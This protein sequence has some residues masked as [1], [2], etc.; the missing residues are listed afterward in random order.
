M[1]RNARR[2]LAAALALA[3]AAGTLTAPASAD[4]AKKPKLSKTSLALKAGKSAKVKIKN[5][6]AK[7][8]KKLTVKTSAKKTATVK[9]NGKTA[10]TV[11]GKKKGSATIT[12]GVKVGKKTTNLKLR[13]K[14]A[15]STV[16]SKTPV[17]PAPSAVPPAT[18]T[19]APPA[20]SAPAT[21]APSDPPSVPTATPLTNYFEDFE[22]GLNGWY[23]RGNEGENGEPG[24]I[25]LEL[26]DEAH[27]GSHSALITGREG[28]DGEGHEWNGPAIDLT[29]TI[30]PGGKYRAT[31]YA[32]VPSD[33][34]TY[35][36]GIDI[37][38]SGAMS[39]SEDDE[40]FENYPRDTWHK[41]PID[42]WKEISVEF[43]VPEYFQSYILYV[44]TH[45]FGKA[46]FLIDDFRLELV[47]APAAYDPSLPSIREAYAP[48]I[49]VMGV[50]VNYGQ[51]LNSN[52]LAFIKHHFNSITMGNEM[53]IDNMLA[54]KETLTLEEAEKRGY[55]VSEAYKACPDNKDAD[56]NVIVPEISFTQTDRVLA[57]AK[58]NGL[59]V[60][61]HSPFWHSQMPQH[62]FTKGYKDYSDLP[63]G[64]G[65]FPERYT[66]KETMYARE[67]MYVQTILH[68]IIEGGY[69][70]TVSS[71]DVVNEYLH[72]VFASLDKYRNFWQC[73]FGNKDMK[74]PYVKKAF[75][76]AHEYLEKQ[77]KRDKIS[78]IYND[79]STYDEVDEV[80]ELINNINAK[81]DMNPTG[82]KVCDGI[83]MQSHVGLDTGAE[84]YENAIKAF[85]AA[86]F[87]IQIT[88]LDVNSGTV[89]SET[90]EEEKAKVWE[91]N[92]K[93]Y[94]EIM[95]VI[96]RQKAKGA[97]ITQVTV[98]GITDAS[99]WM[100]DVAPLLFGA[101]VA[102]KK[103]SFDA[104]VNAALNFKK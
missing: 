30:M 21:Q 78:L 75:V 34:T 69:E 12:A 20:A 13:V 101:T 6:K 36:R 23:G 103:P 66:D 80:I 18:G 8:V 27:S 90:T 2:T 71:F 63:P 17:P 72:M 62:F 41:I 16:P 65:D 24:T 70:D 48:Y 4:A 15:A 19:Q 22:N 55:V 7:K 39:Y 54:T 49:P 3:L 53:K 92:A 82:A 88:E 77:G 26:S 51:F 45:G 98:W 85:H 100:P 50:A 10:F 74:S 84:K 11:T 94:G 57:Q 97:N 14:V 35:K 96:L 58:E 5:V 89:T 87:E 86:G 76:A 73:I 42:D 91:A 9:K 64:P 44:E 47:A 52:T 1:H 83:G 25:K 32:K 104:F 95:D 43:T 79:F 56:G 33:A 102:D 28:V 99:S 93:K 38:L 67:E 81:D 46:P 29:D 60:R 68:H 59:Q 40:T 61:V 31:F 37:M